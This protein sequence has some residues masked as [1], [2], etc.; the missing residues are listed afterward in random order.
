V[1]GVKLE[2]LEKALATRIGQLH[3]KNVTATDGL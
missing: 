2:K 3:A 1:K